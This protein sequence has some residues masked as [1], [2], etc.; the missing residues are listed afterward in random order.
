M[1][2]KLD[3]YGLNRED[4]DSYKEYRKEY[5]KQYLKA[6]RALPD[7]KEKK[8]QYDKE[9][10]A[11]P[12]VKE[13]ITEQRKEYYAHP[14]IKERIKEQRKEYLARPEIKE[15]RTK[16]MKEYNKN[17]RGL[18]NSY[19]SEYKARK[20]KRTPIWSETELIKQFYINCPKGYEVD[21][22]IPLRAKNVS[23]LH[24][25]DNL[26]YLT[27]SENCSKKNTFHSGQEPVVRICEKYL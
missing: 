13:R 22:I 6:Y 23:G 10:R 21:H 8:R 16:Q 19:H 3:K 18:F 25:I 9:Y 17:N 26:Q 20:L 4:F 15:K 1:T 27:K 24:V 5:K 14:E 11:R 12:K 7:G 2:Q